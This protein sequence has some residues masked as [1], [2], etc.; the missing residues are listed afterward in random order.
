MYPLRKHVW[1]LV[2]LSAATIAVYASGV[3]AYFCARD[4]YVERHRA[5]FVDSQDPL[6]IVTTSHFG[7]MRYRP[8]NRGVN[9]LTY[10]FAG[11]DTEWYRIRNLS[12]HVINVLFVYAVG[13]LLLGSPGVAFAGALLFGTHPL[14]HQSVMGA[15]WTNTMAY[16]TFLGSLALFLAA[17]RGRRHRMRRIAAAAFLIFL[18]MLLYEPVVA[19]FG[20][21]AGCLALYGLDREKPPHLWNLIRV[22]AFAAVVVVLL[23][24]GFRTLL[25]SRTFERASASSTTAPRIAANLIIFLGALAQPVDP[26]LANSWFGTPLPSAL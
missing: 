8:L 3:P 10:R 25:V 21:M 2:F 7:G 20:V 23:Q 4:D 13:C 1:A 12:F 16:T 11:N 9:Y 22:F 5:A 6:R 18:G 24:M 26:I 17:V 14:A 15:F 19:V